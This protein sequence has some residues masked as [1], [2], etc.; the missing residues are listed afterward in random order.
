MQSKGLRLL[1]LFA[2]AILLTGVGFAGICP[3]TTLDAYL[4]SGYSC[5][6]DDKTFF[7][8]SY[9]SS[10]NPGGFAIPA[11]GIAVNPITTPGNPGFLF[12]APF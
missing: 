11:N 9:S 2:C 10:S 6:I 5:G 4:G 3:V 1:L 8:F 12:S 7:G